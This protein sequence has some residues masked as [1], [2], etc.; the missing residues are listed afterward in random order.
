MP[1]DNRCIQFSCTIPFPNASTSRQQVRYM[2]ASSFVFVW[3]RRCTPQV[4]YKASTM[5]Q[6]SV[7]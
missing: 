7:D 2:A 3:H 6:F 5:T 4:I 1:K